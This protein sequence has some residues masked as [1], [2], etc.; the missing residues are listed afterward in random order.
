MKPLLSIS[1]TAIQQFRHILT[2][3][4]Q[5]AIFIGLKSGGCNGFEYK[6]KPTNEVGQDDEAF[7][8]DNVKFLVCGKS[9]MYL[10]GTKVDWSSDIMGNQFTFDNPSAKN[11]C[12]CNK[13][14]SIG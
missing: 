5:Q 3:Q 8:V 7:Q 12:G 10:L 9:L 11:T 13:S 6:I 4:N 2:Q 14:F 1:K